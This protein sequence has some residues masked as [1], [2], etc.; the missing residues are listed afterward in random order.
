MGWCDD[1]KSKKNYNR[2]IKIKNKNNFSY[3]KLYRNNSI[4]NYFININFNQKKIKLG[5][6]SAIFLHITKN[7]KKTLGCIA[8]SEKDFIILAKLVNKKTKI[9]IY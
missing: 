7:Y 4:Y 1:P 5:K 2:L 8:L 9:K 6:G 3:E